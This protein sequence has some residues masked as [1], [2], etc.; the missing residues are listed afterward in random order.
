MMHL[1]EDR[2]S[3]AFISRI[4]TN[5]TIRAGGIFAF[6]SFLN[7]G[8]NFLL[9]LILSWYILPSS[10]GQLNLFYTG[11]SV[12]SVL[13]SLSSQG[14]LGVKYFKVSRVVLL[15]YIK[16]ILLSTS[17]MALVF[18][19]VS[20][21]FYDFIEQTI[22]L[23]LTFQ[24][25]CIYICFVSVIYALLT[26]IFRLE[27][28]PISYGILTTI[29][30]L[31]NVVF[32]LYFVITLHLDWTGRIW[33]NVVAETILFIV[34]IWL[35]ITKRYFIFG[36]PT[37]KIF[38]ETLAFSIPLIPHN[39]TGWLRQG[40]DRFII[41]AHFLPSLVGLFSFACNFA[42]IISIAGTAF[43]QSNSVLIY[44][45]L[46]TD[47][48]VGRTY[49]RKQTGI[50][51]FVFLALTSLIII[52]CILFLPFIFP[53]YRQSIKF[54]VPLCFSAFFQCV[55]LLFTNFLFYFQKTR[56]LMAI[57]FTIS[58]VHLILSLVFTPYSVLLTAY[59]SLFSS[60]LQALIVFL[61]SRRLYKLF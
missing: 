49:L 19:F 50:M 16:S 57:T 7:Q 48:E 31:V 34:S 52:S 15:Q 51:F 27:E 6:F 41:N 22:S 45:T 37:Q 55:Y 20:L 26:D 13:I 4:F 40:M 9:L 3:M 23:S 38:K 61:Y 56:Q 42:N 54:L 33:A 32:S 17:L 47:T 44:K 25:I 10:Y 8:L 30:T 60:F 59:I 24:L 21:V 18:L 36:F 53:H 5:K 12:V 2:L 39:L 14:I 28:K 29:N 46:S 58:I 43:N 11:V 35:L 1:K